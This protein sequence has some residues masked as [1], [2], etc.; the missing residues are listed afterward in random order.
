MSTRGTYQKPDP[1]AGLADADRLRFLTALIR[2]GRDPL[3]LA[4][5]A[6]L[7]EVAAMLGA[8][9]ESGHAGRL[10]DVLCTLYRYPEPQP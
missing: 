9:D 5:K 6:M 2:V 3:S 1:W 4:H 8:G 10:L 7:I